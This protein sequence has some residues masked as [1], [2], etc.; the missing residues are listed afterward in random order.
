MAN[1]SVY[2]ESIRAMIFDPQVDAVVVALV[3]F[4]PHLLTTPTEL[5][6]PKSLAARLPAIFRDSTKP[7]LVVIDAGRPYDVLARALRQEGIP[8]FPC[9]DQAIR[10]LGRYLHYFASRN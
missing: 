1:E 9:C 3:P 6:D 10:S 2:D 5:N 8:V 4:T 7:L